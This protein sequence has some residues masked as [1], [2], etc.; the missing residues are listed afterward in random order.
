VFGVPIQGDLLIVKAFLVDYSTQ[1]KV[2]L[3]SISAPLES[4]VNE[5]SCRSLSN[6][7]LLESMFG[8]ALRRAMTFDNVSKRDTT[9]HTLASMSITI[10]EPGTGK[11]IE[12]SSSHK[13]IMSREAMNVENCRTITVESQSPRAVTCTL[14][15][16]SG[17]SMNGKV[18]SLAPL[19]RAP[20]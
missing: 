10:V 16:G 20:V 12:K 11:I 14:I 6:F 17:Q 7:Q 19:R 18:F 5:T 1:K 13:S 9:G 8:L 3:N 2:S 15:E 4:E